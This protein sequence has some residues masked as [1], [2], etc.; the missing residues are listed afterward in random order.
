MLHQVTVLFKSAGWHAPADWQQSCEE[1]HS[2][3]QHHLA[4]RV[5]KIDFPRICDGEREHT[6]PSSS[7]FAK[8]VEHLNARSVGEDSKDVH[9][10]CHDPAMLSFEEQ[11][12]LIYTCIYYMYVYTICMYIRMYVC[13]CM[14][15]RMHVS[16]YIRMYVCMNLCMY[17]YTGG[18]YIYVCV[19]TY[20][21]IFIY[22]YVYIRKMSRFWYDGA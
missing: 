8:F 16:M 11:V 7:H 17:I 6:C 13:V 1:T 21:Y 20:T 3:L 22:M 14:Y 2:T 12:A 4:L 9:L 19:C 5:G 15:I 18:L 10:R